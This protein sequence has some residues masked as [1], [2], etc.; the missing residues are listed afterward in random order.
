MLSKKLFS[1]SAAT[2]SA[3]KKI[4]FEFLFFLSSLPEHWRS[5][6]MVNT[7]FVINGIGKYNWSLCD[8]FR[9][10]E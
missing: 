7:I 6:N 3:L 10:A 9:H 8:G 4:Y 1:F 2:I 5:Y